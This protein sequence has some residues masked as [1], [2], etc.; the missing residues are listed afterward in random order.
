MPY[1]TNNRGADMVRESEARRRDAANAFEPISA[2]LD[3]LEKMMDEHRDLVKEQIQH[4]RSEMDRRINAIAETSL[5]DPSQIKIQFILLD[6][7]RFLPCFTDGSAMQAPNSAKMY[8]GGGVY[9]GANSPHNL[10]IQ[11]N[12]SVRT[13][14]AA[15]MSS[16]ASGLEVAHLV[17][18]SSVQNLLLVVDNM[19]AVMI[20]RTVVE[21]GSEGS[22]SDVLAGVLNSDRSIRDS[23]TSIK[24]NMLRWKEVRVRHVNSHTGRIDSIARGNQHA[25]DLATAACR[26]NFAAGSTNYPSQ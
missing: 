22:N 16:I 24:A 10:E 3:R 19:E 11:M 18:C 15:E 7:L 13:I 21:R 8:F 9:F 5:M 4:I 6:G 20:T 12:A 23:I 1:D 2:S 17:A 25:D 14:L 26:K